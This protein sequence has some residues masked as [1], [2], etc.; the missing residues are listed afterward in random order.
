MDGYRL[1]DTETRGC[2]REIFG[3]LQS[4]DSRGE[5]TANGFFFLAGIQPAHDQ[6]AAV[7]AALAQHN[8][9]VG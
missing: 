5:G 8:A 7:N 2:A 9:F 3:L 6:D 1:C 4:K